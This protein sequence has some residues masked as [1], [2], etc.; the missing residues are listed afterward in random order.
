M[1][2]LALVALVALPTVS[3]GQ[4]P[5][6]ALRAAAKARAD[7]IA[8]ADADAWVRLVSDS[9]TVTFANGR[10]QTKAQRIP[11][12]KA[13]RPGPVAAVPFEH[14]RWSPAGNAYIHQYHNGGLAFTEVWA[15]EHGTWRM[16]TNHLTVIEPDSAVARRMVDSADVAFADAMNRGDAKALAS[17]YS[18]DAVILLQGQAPAAGRAAVDQAF[19]G[20]VGTF[21]ISN[22]RLTTSSVLI[23]GDLIIEHGTYSMT[24]HP[25]AGGADANDTGKYLVVWQEQ[26]DLSWKIVRD[27]S[28]S[29]AAH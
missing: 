6:A 12:I 7:A 11:Q 2:T 19:A 3:L 20:F 14:E 10:V 5:P 25:K 17:F 27:C 24:V 8:R 18:D 26:G 15:K 13:S 29:D 16:A 21:T 28:Q 9:F 23:D 1:K 4:A 22:A